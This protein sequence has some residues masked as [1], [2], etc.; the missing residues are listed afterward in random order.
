MGLGP[1]PLRVGAA[2]G[3]TQ[4]DLRRVE[5][6]LRR[7]GL[8][9]TISTRNPSP[10]PCAGS[11]RQEASRGLLRMILVRAPG[12]VEMARVAAADLPKLLAKG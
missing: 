7:L 10:R 11:L 2:L 1:A 5:H 6:L 12:S 8:P 4:R 9:T 3:V